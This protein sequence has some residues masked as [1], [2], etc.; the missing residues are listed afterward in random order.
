M[1]KEVFGFQTP[2]ESLT[3]WRYLDFEKFMDLIIRN[4]LF[5]TRADK[6]KDPYEG[7]LKLRDEVD[8]E[9]HKLQLETKKFNFLNCWHINENQS[10]AMWKC[11]LKTNNGLAIK[12]TIKKLKKSI[13]NTVEDI[14]IGKVYYR[15]LRKITLSEL[16]KEEQNLLCNGRGGTVNPFCYKRM[17]FEHEKELRIH[18]ID[19]PIPHLKK[20]E[21]KREPLEFKTININIQDL[22]EE[23][24][25]SPFS[26]EWFKGLVED[27]LLKIGLEIKVSKSDLYNLTV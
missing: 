12:T 16:M 23:I 2:N 18:F 24:V 17:D 9:L 5:L 1:Y 14:Y 19:S 20:N 8:Y 4:K 21:E 7:V 25:I 26:D 15:D 10:D 13:D 3:I 6:F 22:I 27:I 11:F